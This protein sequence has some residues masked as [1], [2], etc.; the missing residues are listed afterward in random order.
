[1]LL[2]PPL[3]DDTLNN[4]SLSG[5]EKLDAQFS[6]KQLQGTARTAFVQVLGG[7]AVV[8][9]AMLAWRQ[10][11]HVRLDSKRHADE[12]RDDFHLDLFA[13]SLNR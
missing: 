9:G 1:M 12:K 6:Q 5:K 10:F 13:E 11:Q 7:L 8:S 4:L 2:Y 3:S